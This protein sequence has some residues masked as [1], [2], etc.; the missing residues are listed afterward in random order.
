[1]LT[2]WTYEPRALAR[3][4]QGFHFDA[5]RHDRGVKTWLGREIAEQGQ[6][7]GEMA[8]DVLALHP[9]TARRLGYKLAQ[10][11][12]RDDP[13]PALVERMARTYLD[14]RG[15]IGS[16]LRT[17]FASDEFMDPANV[18]VK[19]K[20]PY[21]FVISAARAGAAP[22]D[23]IGPL[24]GT[25]TQLGMPLYGCQTPDGYKNTQDAWLNTDALGRRITFATAFAAG[26]LQLGGA[27]ARQ[28]APS[29]RSA[30]MPQEWAPTGVALDPR[31]LQL[32]LGA[33]IGETSRLTVAGHPENL[34]AAMLLGSPDFM[35]R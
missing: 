21:Q 17:L 25:M 20:T 13:P 32:T 30:P 3:G 19:F 23:N 18:G 34:R 1:M 31:R 12:V 4:K 35:Q 16:V 27:G 33:V 14:T 8:L 22:V 28:G 29:M 11:F 7:E 24:L 9:T 5:R 6:G 2:G 26:R 10:Y 15:D